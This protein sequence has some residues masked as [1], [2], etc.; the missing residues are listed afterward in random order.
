MVALLAIA[1]HGPLLLMQL[2]AFAAGSQTQMFLA[3]HYANDFFSVWNAQ[4][5]GGFSQT[6]SA[7]LTQQVVALLS[8]LI[9]IT[10]AYMVVQLGVVV[11]LALAVYRFARLFT[12]ER[13]APIAAIGSIFLGSLAM[14][15][16]RE[17]AL[18]A[19]AATALTICGASFLYGWAR[20]NEFFSLLKAVLLLIA[21]AC[22]DSI[23]ALWGVALFALL[24]LWLA[25]ADADDETYGER[26]AAAAVFIR[27]LVAL[28]VAVVISG[29]IMAPFWSAFS[30]SLSCLPSA[31]C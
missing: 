4:W 19:T 12:N 30:P 7:P 14:L 10:A 28:A 8:H 15:V 11:L 1:V 20:G 24:T 27:G 9:G 13:T 26:R 3:K 23:T 29:F 31:I 6:A 2:P 18:P 22:C 21:A 5:F 16:Y 17:G 25:S